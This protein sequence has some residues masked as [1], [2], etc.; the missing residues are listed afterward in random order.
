MIVVENR[1]SYILF[2]VL[3]GAQRQ[4]KWIIPSNCCGVIPAIFHK[5]GT[6]FETCD[7]GVENLCIDLQH[8]SERISQS[9][10]EYAG[11][12]FVYTYGVELE[13]QQAIREFK[14]THPAVMFV[15][16]KCLCR[17]ALSESVADVSDAVLFSTGYAKYVDVGVG[18]YAFIKD[19]LP[20]R[21]HQVS[22]EPEANKALDEA[23]KGA[24]RTGHKLP[25][26]TF[27]GHWLSGGGAIT[28]SDEYFDR[29]K[30]LGQAAEQ[31]KE[32][33][34][35]LY[36]SMLSGDYCLPKTFNHWRFNVVVNEPE[37]L[38]RDLFDAGLF[39]SRHYCPIE[40]F[41]FTTS[42]E[43]K[44]ANWL[45]DHVV[46]LF[47]DKYYSADRAELTGDRV[48]KHV[49]RFGY[50]EPASPKS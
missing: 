2:N 11:V 3:K 35:D 14:E 34:N 6:P 29:V 45:Y 4:G 13:M 9:P 48:R 10:S 27:V 46:N 1:A 24:V 50:P 33:L 49:A 31:Q 15:E 25:P 36:S 21:R 40:R 8:V 22:Y 18:G 38:L 47:N 17:P 7:I 26:S 20:Y 23:I 37:K 42:G 16:D 28:N 32:E 41:D 19:A 5:S 44:T 43:P 12:L 30:I 39:A